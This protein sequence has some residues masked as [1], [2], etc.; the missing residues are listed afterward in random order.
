MPNAKPMVT[1]TSDTAALT[2]ADQRGGEQH[3]QHCDDQRDPP[4]PPAQIEA[5][6]HRAP[7]FSRADVGNTP[8]LPREDRGRHRP[9]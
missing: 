4:R 2:H 7:V 1:K 9:T 6:G 5:S 3:R 8:I